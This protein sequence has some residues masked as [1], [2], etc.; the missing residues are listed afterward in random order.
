MGKE[1]V[2][3]IFT[4]MAGLLMALIA[5]PNH[6]HFRTFNLD[7]GMFHAA[8]WDFIHGKSN[9]ANLLLFL[10]DTDFFLCHFSIPP[11]FISLFFPITGSYTFILAQIFFILWGGRGIY[12]LYQLKY[13]DAQKPWVILFH[14]LVIWG[15]YSA[16]SSE[17]HDNVVGMMFLPWVLVFLHH[18]RIGLSILC[19]V[20]LLMSKEN[21]A[22]VGPFF[23]LGFLILE[24]SSP[25]KKWLYLHLSISIIWVIMLFGMI[26]PAI[27]T[28]HLGPIQ[29]ERYINHHGVSFERWLM[30]VISSPHQWI[31]YAFQNTS[32]NP[33][34]DGIKIEF[35]WVWLLSGGI[36]CWIRPALLLLAGPVLAFKLLPWDSYTLWGIN[37]Q[38]SI[39]ISMITILGMIYIPPWIR[40]Y[41]WVF[42]M[43]AFL[44]TIYTW[45]N[46][47]SKWH[48]PVMVSIFSKD[49]Y[50]RSFSTTSVH[51]LLQKIPSEPSI[52]VSAE[53]GPWLAYRDTA[54]SFPNI[55][56]AQW[57][58]LMM[59]GENT[60]PLPKDTYIKMADSLKKSDAWMV[61]IDQYPLLVLERKP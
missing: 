56:K 46:R 40:P 37:Y 3:W 18:R 53:L 60:Y 12:V 48:D 19:W 57:I 2:F 26:F 16:V 28:Q 21:L 13:P 1:K 5:I 39:E 36:I 42:A 31:Q 47:E 45:Q 17:Y 4:L 27:D 23:A 33:E 6:Y 11:L 29:A 14:F 8:A 59:H 55:S 41:S 49:H 15:I 58:A 43:G 34:F 54:Y 24:W 9:Q 35:W 10:P 32:G 25:Q 61:R 52:C 38:Y 30:E 22:A 50:Q 44:S 7:L 51:Q 20:I